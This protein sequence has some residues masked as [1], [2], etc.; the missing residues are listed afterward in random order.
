MNYEENCNPNYFPIFIRLR[1]GFAWKEYQ[2]LRQG[3][4]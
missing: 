1:P 4:Y 3:L 2:G